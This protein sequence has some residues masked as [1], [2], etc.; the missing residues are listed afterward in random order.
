MLRQIFY[1]CW[2]LSLLLSGC[3]G[4]GGDDTATTTNPPAPPSSYSSS[5]SS[6]TPTPPTPPTPGT[7][8]PNNA[9]NYRANPLFTQAWHLY[10]RTTNSSYV[11]GEDYNV[12][13]VWDC[14]VAGS[15]VN[16]AVV[17]QGLEI[18][19]EDLSANILAGQ[20]YRYFDGS[21][22]PSPV[23]RSQTHGTMVGGTIAAASNLF[24]SLGVAPKASLFGFNL[25]E[26]SPP[27][28]SS[29]NAMVGTTNNG[30]TDRFQS[31]HVS[32][33]SWGYV[34]TDIGS[35]LFEYG[36]WKDVIE[37]GVTNG[38]NGKGIIYLFA[39]GNDGLEA[40]TNHSPL[41][42]YRSVLTIG[43]ADSLGGH[44]SYAQTGATL[45][46]SGL[47]LGKTT[48]GIYQ[49]GGITTTTVPGRGTSG[50]NYVSTFNGTSAAT[51]GVAGVVAL[52][53][54]A[55]PDLTWRQVRWILADS[56]RKNLDTSGWLPAAVGVG[57]NHL[58]GFGIPD[59]NVAVTKAKT[60]PTLGSLSSCAVSTTSTLN[61]TLSNT[62][63]VLN[64]DVSACSLTKVEFVEVETSFKTDNFA[65]F[66]M[67]L[68]SAGG[69]QSFL[70]KEHNACDGSYACDYGGGTSWTFGTVRHLGESL[71]QAGLPWT[72]SLQDTSGS[73]NASVS[74]IR[75]VFW[76]Y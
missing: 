22:D 9:P 46:V 37:Q 28:A 71:K 34:Q 36:L 74:G 7:C 56:A 31:I 66:V 48:T 60:P 15:G 45:L 69:Y 32:N 12:T 6:T 33:N 30:N 64:F 23:T 54:S 68:T 4:G 53:L 2:V 70:A 3:G 47:T 72:I 63:T 8:Q 58:Y 44:P 19:H 14:G 50:G 65:R 67:T 62:S 27:A 21:T 1:G 52:M 75:L 24:G 29:L 73:A 18:T 57:Y 38:R 20:S 43:G 41:T 40:D 26:G 17:D 76:G 59:A 42:K 55:N 39:A 51:P 35:L 61:T 16:V 49:G 13:P 25:L 10:N 11:S 5:G